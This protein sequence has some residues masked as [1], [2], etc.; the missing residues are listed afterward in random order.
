MIFL[1][2]LL[3]V[4]ITNYWSVWNRRSYGFMQWNMLF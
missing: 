1:L 3:N 2:V 4:M